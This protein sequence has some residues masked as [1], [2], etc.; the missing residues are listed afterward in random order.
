MIASYRANQAV[1][2]YPVFTDYQGAA[3]TPISATFTV[4]DREGLLAAAQPVDLY[5]GDVP[6]LTVPAAQNQLS[7]GTN[8]GY[9]RIEIVYTAE[10]GTVYNTS[11]TYFIE[12]SNA[13]VVGTNSFASL[14]DLLL[15]SADMI[16]LRVFQASI[17]AR[18]V[19]ALIGAWH[20]LGQLPV[21][22]AD[23]EGTDR[24]LIGSTTELIDADI[25]LLQPK[26]YQRLLRAQVIEANDILGGN[27][28]EA[29][30][31][32]GLMSDSAGESAHFF[33][34]SKPLTLPA[35]RAAVEEL[36]GIVNWTVRASR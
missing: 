3:L 36:R 33:R 16:D 2:L 11:I 24:Y 19:S 18:Q 17:E 13:L 15:V 34:S 8:R 25:T 22:F 1:T 29:R 31:R 21:R 12:G 7:A 6:F 26:T 4:H 5:S 30:R 10:T 32:A 27:P 14:A 23:L 9:R 35:C 20:N 28:I